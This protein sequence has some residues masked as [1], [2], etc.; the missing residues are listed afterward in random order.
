[1]TSAAQ[2]HWAKKGDIDLYMHR[3]HLPGKSDVPRPVL[4]LVHGSTQSA[5]IDELAE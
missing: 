2:D 3:E 4:F 5:R 1:M